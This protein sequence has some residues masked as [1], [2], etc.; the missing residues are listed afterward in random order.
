[1]KKTKFFKIKYTLNNHK[2]CKYEGDKSQ[3]WQ[4]EDII[5]ETTRKKATTFLKEKYSYNDRGISKE[6][7]Y[8]NINQ[9][10]DL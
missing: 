6:S 10:I 3:T 4:L 8:V 1:M 5:E 7:Q 9:V 2:N